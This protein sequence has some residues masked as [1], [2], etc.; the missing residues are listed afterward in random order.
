MKNS[1]GGI[2]TALVGFL[3]GCESNTELNQVNCGINTPNDLVESQLIEEGVLDDPNAEEQENSEVPTVVVEISINADQITP[4]DLSITSRIVSNQ[5][6]GLFLQIKEGDIDSWVETEN[7][8]RLD[9]DPSK[10]IA[11]EDGATLAEYHFDLAGDVESPADDKEVFVQ[12]NCQWQV[13]SESDSLGSCTG[14]ILEDCKAVGET[15]QN[16]AQECKERARITDANTGWYLE[17]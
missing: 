6:R 12:A 3:A 1:L 11:C 7:F 15:I 8:G 17:Y 13:S 2:G 4:T 9:Q 5:I 14:T 16:L 10:F